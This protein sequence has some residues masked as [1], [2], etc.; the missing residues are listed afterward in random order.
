MKLEKEFM[1]TLEIRSHFIFFY[2]KHKRFVS[3]P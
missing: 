1:C 2:Y 3:I